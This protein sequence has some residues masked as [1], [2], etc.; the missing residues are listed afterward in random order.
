MSSKWI[1]GLM[2]LWVILTILANTAEQQALMGTGQTS[3]LMAFMRPEGMNLDNPVTAIV[4]IITNVWTYFKLI[5]NVL[6][7]NYPVLWQGSGIYIYFALF[8]PVSIG[9][10][11]SVIALLRGASSS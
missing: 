5:I 11:V 7:F 1:I 9:F 4:S 6:F 10:V 2:M 8:L 3:T